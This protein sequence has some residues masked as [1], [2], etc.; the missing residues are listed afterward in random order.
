[1]EKL[2]KPSVIIPNYGALRAMDALAF[3]VPESPG[4]VPNL[5][6]E[7]PL[8]PGAASAGKYDSGP[9]GY[10]AKFTEAVNETLTV[11][12]EPTSPLTFGNMATFFGVLSISSLGSNKN[13]AAAGGMD[14]RYEP[15]FSIDSTNG[16]R[17]CY[18]DGGYTEVD[19]QSIGS[20]PATDT[21]IAF[22]IR[23]SGSSYANLR[24]IHTSDGKSVTGTAST[25]SYRDTLG[26]TRAPPTIGGATSTSGFTGNIYQFGFSNRLW[27]D[28]E[29]Q[30]YLS[31]PWEC[32]RP[33]TLAERFGATFPTPPPPPPPTG[34]SLY[35]VTFLQM[36][37]GLRLGNM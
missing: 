7:G 2:L 14:S 13:F 23:M 30:R 16:F 11:L 9:G 3:Y 26:T 32:V 25:A 21:P 29:I 24:S 18:V 8:T 19:I 15:R 35:A 20:P 4:Y 10:G 28:D 17:T 37:N 31:N 5:V 12:S 33:R 36:N 1:M 6:G 27:G 22:V 34:S